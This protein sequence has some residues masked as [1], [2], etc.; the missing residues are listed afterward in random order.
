MAADTARV[1]HVTITCGDWQACRTFYEAL[2]LTFAEAEHKGVPLHVSAQIGGTVLELVTPGLPGGGP[3]SSGFRL[4]LEVPD[5]Q[6][7][8]DALVAAGGV[9]LRA[10]A[11][12]PSGVRA[13]V[14]DPD[15]R[16]IELIAPRS[17]EDR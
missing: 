17:H 12:G 2:G 8:A 6:A 13:A 9:L 10:P 1:S 7:A 5:V 15:G 14:I 3:A 16:R 4:G 11:A